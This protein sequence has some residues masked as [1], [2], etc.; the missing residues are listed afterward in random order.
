MNSTASTPPAARTF[1]TGTLRRAVIEY[2]IDLCAWQRTELSKRHRADE[3]YVQRRPFAVHGS[4]DVSGLC[5]RIGALT[6]GLLDDF[7]AAAREF[8]ER[9]TTAI[10]TLRDH[11]ADEAVLRE[12]FGRLFAFQYPAAPPRSGGLT[13]E[14]AE[15]GIR[16]RTGGGDFLEAIARH[17]ADAREHGHRP[18]ADETLAVYLAY[19]LIND[20]D[21]LPIPAKPWGSPGFRDI[22]TYM[23]VTDPGEGH[24]LGTT[25]D[26]TYLNGVIVH[27]EH[28]ERGITQ[29]R[30]DVEPYRIP[31]PPRVISRV[32][33]HTGTIAPVSSY[34]G[35]PMFEGSVR[36]SM[37]K[38]V[39]TTAA[40]CS[41]LFGDGLT[42]CK[43]A[44]ERMT[45]T[46]AVEFMSA[47]VG[48]VRRDRHRQVL[49]AAF[50]L[51]TP[52]LDDRVETLRANGGRPQ[53]AADRYSI[54][55]LGIELA[56][57]G[58]FDK[59]TWD[60][61]ADTYPSRCVI[62]QLAFEQAVAL[63][64]RAHEA[65][66]LTYFSAGFRFVHPDRHQLELIAQLIDAGQMMPNVD[67]VF[68]FGEIAAAHR[69]GEQ[70]HVRG[71]LLVDLTR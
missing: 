55:L 29:S 28:L 34:V 41:S 33:L 38:T 27:V 57:A 50:N 7:P 18:T 54:G 9:M 40:A 37:L 24:L 8:V 64:H 71:K 32:R 20:G 21:R 61:T 49:S 45:A 35:R 39:H 51:N 16:V 23:S 65:G 48:N 44:I 15:G 47:I 3:N 70:G 6:T 22:Q 68:G 11:R 56:A 2:A 58:G 30:E 31:N 60:G 5:A 10:P 69:Y 62:E 17:L 66:L 53:L 14:P 1:T 36:D 46:E 52:I 4:D 42:E 26:A 13:V 59:V 67:R 19:T 25:R 43:L 63:V 12:Q